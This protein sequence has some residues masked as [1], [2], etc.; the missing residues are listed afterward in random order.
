MDKRDDENKS[1]HRIPTLVCPRDATRTRFWRRF[2][3]EFHI[4][5][6]LEAGREICKISINLKIKE[7]L[8]LVIRI[9]G[10][11]PRQVF[12]FVPERVSMN[13]QVVLACI[14]EEIGC[15][16]QITIKLWYNQVL[17]NTNTSTDRGQFLELCFRK[18]IIKKF[19]QRQLGFRLQF[20]NAFLAERLYITRGVFFTISILVQN[21]ENHIL[22]SCVFTSQNF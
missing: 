14:G 19:H 20:S 12:V 8:I 18:G 6:S 16:L 9:L 3:S 13:H 21:V 4:Q 7:L 11:I 2:R 5:K 17:P 10:V 15:F 1:W 22:E